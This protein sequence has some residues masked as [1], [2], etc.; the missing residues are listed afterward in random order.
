MDRTDGID[1]AGPFRW[2]V[3]AMRPAA[4]LVLIVLTTA[5]SIWLTVLGAPLATE[6]APDGIV[7]FELARSAEASARVL[8]SW[9]APAREAA[10]LVQGVDFLFLLAYPAFFSLAAVQLGR[11]LG[12][13]WQRLGVRLAWAVWL[14]AP[15]DAIENLALIRQLER[16]ASE[17]AALFAW[18][19]A[20]PKFALVC[21][22]AG[23]VLAGLLALGWRATRNAPE[24]E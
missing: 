4:L 20:L 21:L 1:M 7:S 2:I 10:M 18:A 22:L 6:A 19:C 14:A 11:R 9:D 13:P 16:G 12:V 23:F 5:L 8:A 3:P 15:L 17:G 24:N